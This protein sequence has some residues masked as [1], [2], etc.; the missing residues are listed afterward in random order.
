MKKDVLIYFDLITSFRTT[1]EVGNFV[2][3]IDSLMSA[4]F[5]SEKVSIEEA[6][7]SI[8]MDSA[9]KIKEI[10][11]KNNLNINDRDEVSDF[12]ENLKELLKKFKV[13]K[14]VLAF[15]PTLR[16][17]ENIHNFVR[18]TIGIGYILDIEVSESILGG[19][20]V[21]FNGK[22]SDFTLKKSLENTFISKKKEILLAVG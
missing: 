4:F 2:S 6:L 19:A 16:T 3:E 9:K 22:Y 18:E 13:I 5:K 11:L 15:N 1:Q 12:F 7:N 21:I 14:L 17:I 8:S 20:I 10:I